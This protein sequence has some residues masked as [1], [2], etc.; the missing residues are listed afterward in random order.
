MLRDSCGSIG[1]FVSRAQSHKLITMLEAPKSVEEDVEKIES[2]K[3]RR[4]RHSNA[5]QVPRR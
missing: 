3:Q 1:S 2:E 4:A 5:E